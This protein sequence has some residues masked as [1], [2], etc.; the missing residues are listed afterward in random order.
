MLVT[1]TFRK[2]R[3]DVCE[4]PGHGSCVQARV[5]CIGCLAYHIYRYYHVYQHIYGA[6]DTCSKVFNFPASVRSIICG[7][8]IKSPHHGKQQPGRPA[9]TRVHLSNTSSVCPS[10]CCASKYPRVQPGTLSIYNSSWHPGKPCSTSLPTAVRVLFYD[11]PIRSKGTANT[12][13]SKYANTPRP[14]YADNRETDHRPCNYHRL[15]C[16]TTLCE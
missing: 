12:T 15:E 10:T 4:V 1:A 6:C 16:W 8:K 13:R 7:L 11:C 5:A 9:R 3:D 14:K 2:F